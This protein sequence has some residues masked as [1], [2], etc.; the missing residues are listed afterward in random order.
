MY[1]KNRKSVPLFVQLVSHC[2]SLLLGFV[3]LCESAV[4]LTNRSVRVDQSVPTP[5]CLCVRASLRV[6]RYGV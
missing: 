3:L 1:R 5:V 4:Q 6:F 2:A